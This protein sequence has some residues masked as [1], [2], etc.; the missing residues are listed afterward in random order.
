MSSYD[1]LYD[2]ERDARSWKP[3]LDVAQERARQT[4]AEKE[5]TNIYDNTAVLK[6][7]VGLQMVLRDLLDALDA[8][9]GR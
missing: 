6:A 8:K 7:A 3:S 2:A 1:P 4:L 5:S 9:A